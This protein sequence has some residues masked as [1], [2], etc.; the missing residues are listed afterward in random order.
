MKIIINRLITL[1]LMYL[2]PIIN[3]CMFCSNYSDRELILVNSCCV[4]SSTAAAVACTI[5]GLK[6]ER[7]RWF[8]FG[9]VQLISLAFAL[10]SNCLCMAYIL[11]GKSLLSLPWIICFTT[12]S[13]VLIIILTLIYEKHLSDMIKAF[14]RNIKRKRKDKKDKIELLKKADAVSKKQSKINVK[15]KGEE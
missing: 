3:I 15:K 8:D 1:S 4:L 6:N 14:E 13:N 2:I 11:L 5:K 7:N 12:L 9:A 10:T